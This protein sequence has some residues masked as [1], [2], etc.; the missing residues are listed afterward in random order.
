MSCQPSICFVKLIPEV[1]NVSGLVAE[2]KESDETEYPVAE[3][4]RNISVVAA[5][6]AI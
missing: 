4:F 6:L 1:D 5:N 2:V 3:C